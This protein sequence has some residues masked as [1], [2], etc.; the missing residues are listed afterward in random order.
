MDAAAPAGLFGA[1][2]LHLYQFYSLLLKLSLRR[3]KF[4]AALTDDADPWQPETPAN[5]RSTS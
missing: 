2:G 1:G 3:A 5:S 4:A